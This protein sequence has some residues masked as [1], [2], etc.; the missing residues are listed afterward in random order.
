MATEGG[1]DQVDGRDH[2]RRVVAWRGAASVATMAQAAEASDRV[3]D[4]IILCSGDI[5]RCSG[6]R[7]YSSSA[8]ACCGEQAPGR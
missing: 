8:I 5:I 2:T 3:A 7:S 6:L 4:D 1:L